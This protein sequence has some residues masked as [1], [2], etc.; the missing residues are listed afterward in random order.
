MRFG[1][2]SLHKG[3]QGV[4]AAAHKQ[5]PASALPRMDS[6]RLGGLCPGRVL[7]IG[8]SIIGLAAAA[9]QA[10]SVSSCV[11]QKKQSAAK[12]CEERLTD[13][14]GRDRRRALCCSSLMA[15]C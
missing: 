4:P 14:P 15:S 12:A 6:T 2:L 8:A 5:L 9:Q 10:G 13:L 11:A 1:S 3:C 7:S